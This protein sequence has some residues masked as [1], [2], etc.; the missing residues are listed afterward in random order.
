MGRNNLPR[1]EKL[2]PIRVWVKR[3]TIEKLGID[4]IRLVSAEAIEKSLKMDSNG[5][6]KVL[7]HIY[8]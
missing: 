2:L 5:F 6:Y 3:G 7:Y 4:K 1:E 8:F